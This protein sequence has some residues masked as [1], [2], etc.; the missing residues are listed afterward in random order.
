MISLILQIT[1]IFDCHINAIFAK[2]V[3][4]SISIDI[5]SVVNSR[6]RKR[7]GFKLSLWEVKLRFKSYGLFF[8]VD[9]IRLKAFSVGIKI[10]NNSL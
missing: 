4:V 3:F 1:I 5:I 9:D 7:R 6:E 10:S 2:I 8:G